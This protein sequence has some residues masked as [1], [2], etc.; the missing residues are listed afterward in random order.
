MEFGWRIIVI[1]IRGKHIDCYF[2]DIETFDRH[3]ETTYGEKTYG[4]LCV[5]ERNRF[6]FRSTLTTSYYNN[7]NVLITF[8]R[9]ECG[10]IRRRSVKTETNYN[11][12]GDRS[13][14][15]GRIFMYALQAWAINTN[16]IVALINYIIIRV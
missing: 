12:T 10:E 7:Y 5:T 16:L 8:E 13:A 15:P 1:R 9:N 3:E 11:N 2:W 14:I 4:S 6:F